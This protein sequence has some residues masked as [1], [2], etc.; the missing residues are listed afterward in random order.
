MVQDSHTVTDP[1]TRWNYAENDKEQRNGLIPT[2]LGNP[3]TLYRNNLT[4]D[5]T[6]TAS[7]VA[8]GDSVNAI[9]EQYFATQ[10]AFTRT[11]GIVGMDDPDPNLINEII[12]ENNLP[13]MVTSDSDAT[14]DT[15]TL[16]D[17]IKQANSQSGVSS[18]EFADPLTGST[19]NTIV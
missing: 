13:I 15:G 3:S 17:A 7:P 14:G 1:N 6:S 2:D 8:L 19:G 16:R 11:T 5:S 18:I 10:R 12:N 4:Q 9:A